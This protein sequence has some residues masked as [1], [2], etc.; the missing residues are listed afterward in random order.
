MEDEPDMNEEFEKFED[1]MDEELRNTFTSKFKLSMYQYAAGQ[2]LDQ[3]EKDTEIKCKDHI[4]EFQKYVF[5][6]GNDNYKAKHKPGKQIEAE[7]SYKRLEKCS[8]FMFET[9]SDLNENVEFAER[10][11]YH[12]FNICRM[13]CFKKMNPL[14][15]GKIQVCLRK[16]R[17]YTFSYIDRATEDALLKWIVIKARSVDTRNYNETFEKMWYPK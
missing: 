14:N 12:Q 2:I 5:I 3:A 8:E 11:Y 17:F 1:K 9:L 6:D 15:I 4:K 13:N 7:L 10:F 16:C